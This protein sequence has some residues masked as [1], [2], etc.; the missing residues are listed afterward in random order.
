M[1]EGCLVDRGRQ[2][3]GLGNE[4]K[5][6]GGFVELDRYILCNVIYL[7]RNGPKTRDGP[8]LDI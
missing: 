6:D 4:A 8:T 1:Q 7:P 2:V 5:E 3:A